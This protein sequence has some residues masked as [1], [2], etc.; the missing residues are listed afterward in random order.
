MNGGS[1]I[2]PAMTTMIVNGEIVYS[3][4]RHN[5]APALHA[6][7]RRITDQARIR[8]RGAVASVAGRPTRRNT[9]RTDDRRA[10][11][12]DT[13]TSGPSRLNQ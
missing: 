13:V 10:G 4:A 9:R 11:G 1:T 2:A 3:A 6:R 12:R 5:P 8:S 7:H